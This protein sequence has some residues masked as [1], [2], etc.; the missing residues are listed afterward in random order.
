MRHSVAGFQR[1]DDPLLRAAELE[2]FQRFL[3]GDRDIFR[4]ANLVQPAVFRPDAGVIKTRRDGIPFEDLTIVILQKIGAVAMKNAGA[5]TSERGA[6]LHLLV[7]AFTA[8]LNPDD[9]DLLVIKEGKEQAHG[10]RPAAY[11]GGSNA[12]GLFFPFLDDK[13]ER[14]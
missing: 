6:M 11:G 13:E 10:V 4:A 9:V 7:D 2:G 5:A 3:V 12:M 1:G 8:G 14:T